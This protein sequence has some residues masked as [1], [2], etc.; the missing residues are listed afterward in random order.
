MN[1]EVKLDQSCKEL[2]LIIITREMNDEVSSLLQKINEPSV[3]MFSG[4]HEGEVQLI[5]QEEI[6]RIYTESNKVYISTKKG[7]FQIKLRLYECENKLNTKIF[8]RISNSEIINLKE[9]LNFDLNYSGTIHVKM[10]NGES[11]FVSRRYVT[12]IKKVLGL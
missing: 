9:V 5:E 7:L 11:T 6:N 4:I 2:R 12:K 8:V 10:K 1:V 3:D